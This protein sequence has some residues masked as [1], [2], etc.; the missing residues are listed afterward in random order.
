MEIFYGGGPQRSDS[1][2]SS[3]FIFA[4]YDAKMKGDDALDS[5]RGGPPEILIS[6]M[7]QR[8]ITYDQN[9][10]ENNFIKSESLFDHYLEPKRPFSKFWPILA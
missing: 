3:P 2:A 6:R 4:S 9:E 8:V 7:T 10:V 1:N 5:K